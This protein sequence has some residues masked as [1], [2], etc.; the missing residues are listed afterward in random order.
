MKRFYKVATVAVLEGG[1]GINLDGRPLRT[2]ARALLSVPGERLADA[3]ADEWNAQGDEI[4]PGGMIMTGLSN[5]AIDQIAPDT[6]SF[7]ASVA[8]YGES[9]LFCYRAAGPDS[10]VQEQIKAWNP[11]LDWAERHFGISFNLATGIMHVAQSEATVERLSAEVMACDPFTLAGLST[12]VTMSGSLVGGLA[13]LEGAFA[14]KQVWIAS[15]LD[16]LWQAKTWG[17]DVQ[18]AQRR[19]RR[20]SEFEEAARFLALARN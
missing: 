10:L 7:A 5:A 16:E 19:A 18:A 17:E 11:L 12:L 14:V 20:Q 8:A 15:E 2:P 6:A 3:I 13:I 1:F 4:D 9:D